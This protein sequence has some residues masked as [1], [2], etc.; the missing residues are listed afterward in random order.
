MSNDLQEYK[1]KIREILLN[2]LYK[3]SSIQNNINCGKK[4]INNI[5]DINKNEKGG[6]LNFKKIGKT[7]KNVGNDIKNETQKIATKELSKQ[8]FKQIGKQF[9][10]GLN[11]TKEYLQNEVAPALENIGEEALPILEE[12]PLMAA[13]IKKKKSLSQKMINRNELIKKIMYKFNYSLPE[14]SRYIKEHNLKY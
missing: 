10:N 2:D 3:Q 11:M 6:N 7:F 8:A 9:N 1:N 13:G 12:V 4:N 5:Q 14:A